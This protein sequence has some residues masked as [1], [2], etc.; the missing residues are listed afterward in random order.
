MNLFTSCQQRTRCLPLGYLHAQSDAL[1]VSLY[2]H[3]IRL[4]GPNT[5][6]YVKPLSQTHLTAEANNSS[7]LSWGVLMP[8]VQLSRAIVIM[9]KTPIRNICEMP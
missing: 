3:M 4:A 9:R 5:F 8:K 2:L 7:F 1:Y 6:T